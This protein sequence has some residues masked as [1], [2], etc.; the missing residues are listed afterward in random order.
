MQITVMELLAALDNTVRL[1]AI[2]LMAR[3]GELCVCELTHALGMSQPMVSRHLAILRA[4]GLVNDRRAGQWVY[5]SLHPD[6]DAPSRAVVDA[7]VE[8]ASSQQPF[9]NDIALLQTMPDRP[10]APCG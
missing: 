4:Y 1:R 10:D 8:A 2:V 7:A 9:R 6:L 3:Q 5:Y